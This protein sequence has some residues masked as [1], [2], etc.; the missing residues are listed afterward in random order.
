MFNRRVF[1]VRL[2]VLV[3][4]QALTFADGEVELHLVKLDNW[5]TAASA[6]DDG[7]EHYDL[8]SELLTSL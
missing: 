6:V 7:V 2:I 4:S 3:C 8:L 5:K 1:I